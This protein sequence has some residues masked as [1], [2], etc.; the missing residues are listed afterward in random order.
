MSQGS[1]DYTQ[2]NGGDHQ[3]HQIR[4]EIF[5]DLWERFTDLYKF[6]GGKK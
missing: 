3:L 2:G 4:R 5:Q 6:S 1:D